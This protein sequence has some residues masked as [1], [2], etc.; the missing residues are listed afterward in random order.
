[1]KMTT[2]ERRFSYF[3]NAFLSILALICLLPYINLL[4]KSFSSEGQVLAG[5]VTFWPLGFNLSA[6]EGLLRIPTFKIAFR[7]SVITTV[8]ATVTHTFFTICIGYVCSKEHIPGSRIIQRLYVFSMLFGGGLI[9][10]YIVIRACGLTNNLLVLVIPGMVAPFNMFMAR[11]YF[12]TIPDSLEESAKL[13]GANNLTVFFRI[14]LPM[15]IPSIATVTIFIAVGV[16]NSYMGPKI[17]LTKPNVV[18]L[19]LY[20]KQ[21]VDAANLANTAEGMEMLQNVAAASF[22]AAAVFISTLPILLVYPF[23]QKYFIVGMTLGAVKQ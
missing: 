8:L 21:I 16:W 22:R 4:A 13:D 12:Y 2:G 11:N 23:L 6:Y 20:L 1:M 10:T 9:P 5:N 7:N 18:T 17:Y 3:N 19:S 15:A 14:M